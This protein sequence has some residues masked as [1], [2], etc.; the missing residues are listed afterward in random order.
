MLVHYFDEF[1]FCIII[2]F[3]GQR[4]VVS[5][6]GRTCRINEWITFTCRDISEAV[7]WQLN[8]IDLSAS[9]ND[10]YSRE[11]LNLQ[12][13]CEIQWNNTDVTCSDLNGER[14]PPATILIHA[15]GIDFHWVCVCGDVCGCV[16]VWV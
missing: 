16:H 3:S 6:E 11:N 1:L 7:Q 10:S 8:G 12:I 4:P 13:K 2:H 14:S 15:P 9:G 5:P